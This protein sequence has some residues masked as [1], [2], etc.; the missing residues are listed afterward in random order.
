MIVLNAADAGISGG[1]PLLPDMKSVSE[2]YIA[3]QIVPWTVVD[4]ERGIELEIWRDVAGET[5]GR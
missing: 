5:D 3:K 4:V 2:D 1:Q